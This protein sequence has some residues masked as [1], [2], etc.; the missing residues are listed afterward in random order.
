MIDTL[1]VAARDGDM[2]VFALLDAVPGPT[3]TVT[4]LDLVAVRPAPLDRHN[5]PEIVASGI[6]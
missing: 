1:Y 2:I 3:L 6:P 5:F 4:L